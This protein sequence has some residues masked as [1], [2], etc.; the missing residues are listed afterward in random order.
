MGQGWR[1]APSY[2]DIADWVSRC[3]QLAILLEVSAYPKPGNVHR[4]ADFPETKYE[5]FL[6]SAIACGPSFSRLA[7]KGAMMGRRRLRAEKIGLG[8][9]VKLAIQSINEWQ[10]GGNTLLGSVLLLA[11]LAGAAGAAMATK[12]STERLRQ[13]LRKI[14]M[15]STPEDA[16][17]VYEAISL[18]KPGGLGRVPDLDV[19]NPASRLKILA[20]GI[21]L[22]DIFLLSS[23]Y[24]MIAKEW[25]T[26]FSTTF[27]LAYPSLVGKLKGSDINAAIVDTFLAILS[28]VPDTLIAREF[29]EAKAR[30][31]SAYAEKVLSM[32]GV[33]SPKGIE[34]VRAFDDYLRKNDM[35]PGATADIL[36]AALAIAVL[37]GFRP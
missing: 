9:A 33:G 8:R 28:K 25:V 11:P 4:L 7:V 23:K 1:N 32:G 13:F 15:A 6:A 10:R 3:L 20:D 36:S 35:N 29:G 24:D 21:R 14:V 19:N 27:E 2:A 22:Y 17:R 18:A 37:N 5:H 34:Q 31:V 26:G 30:E 12:F 16:L